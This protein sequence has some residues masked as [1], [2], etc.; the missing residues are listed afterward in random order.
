[1]R[2]NVAMRH[3]WFL[4]KRSAYF[5]EDGRKSL[6]R[7]RDSGYTVTNLSPG[8]QYLY[9]DTKIPTLEEALE[10]IVAADKYGVDRLKRICERKMISALSVENATTLLC[11]AELCNAEVLRNQAINASSLYSRM[12]TCNLIERRKQ[13][14][15]SMKSRSF[16]TQSYTR[17]KHFL[18]VIGGKGFVGSN[19]LQHALQKGIEV[20]SLNPSGKP[21]WPDAP[22]INDVEWIQG[23][24]F[25]PT[26]VSLA[27]KGI[28]GVISTVG[29]F[30]NQDHMEKLCGDATISAVTEAKK[31]G[32][33][34]F[35]FI[36]NSKVG[37]FIPSWSPLYGYYHGKERAEASI[38]EN[39]PETGVC[40][41]PGFIY[42]WRRTG[43]TNLPL[44]LFGVPMTIASRKL[45]ALSAVVSNVPFIGS[46]M[47]AAVPV[48]ATAETS[49]IMLQNPSTLPPLG[50][51]LQRLN[52]AHVLH[53]NTT[54]KIQYKLEVKRPAK[55][56]SKP[57]APRGTTLDNQP[58]RKSQSHYTASPSSATKLM[59]FD[60]CWSPAASL[61]PRN[62]YL[63]E[64]NSILPVHSYPEAQHQSTYCVQQKQWRTLIFP[65]LQPRTRQQVI[66]LQ[67]TLQKMIQNHEESSSD[68][69]SL[70]CERIL[71]EYKV[72]QLCFHELIRQM[73]FHCREQG[74]L[75]FHIYRRY[76]EMLK[77]L[78]DSLAQQETMTQRLEQRLKDLQAQQQLTP[79]QLIPSAVEDEDEPKDL[80][81]MIEVVET[82]SCECHAK[83][84]QVE[85]MAWQIQRLEL[86][87]Q[88]HILTRSLRQDAKDDASLD[89]AEISCERL[90]VSWEKMMHAAVFIQ[91]RFRAFRVY[92]YVKHHR[93]VARVRKQCRC[94][95]V[96]VTCIQAAVRRFFARQK[97]LDTRAL[98]PADDSHHA[99]NV[100]NTSPL[101]HIENLI[102]ALPELKRFIEEE[103]SQAVIVSRN[104]KVRDLTL[105]QAR[106]LSVRL[107]DVLGILSIPEDTSSIQETSSF[108]MEQPLPRTYRHAS[109]STSDFACIV[110]HEMIQNDKH[111]VLDDGGDPGPHLRVIQTV[112]PILIAE[113]FMEP[114]EPSYY[115]IPQVPTL[116][117]SNHPETLLVPLPRKQKTKLIT[118]RQFMTTIYDILLDKMKA[119]LQPQQIY[120]CEWRPISD[121]LLATKT[122]LCYSI[123]EWQ[124]GWDNRGLLAKLD[125]VH[126]IQQHFRFQF[127]L[128]NLTESAWKHLFDSL[129]Q[130]ASMHPD[131]QRFQQLLKMR[132]ESA[133]VIFYLICRQLAWNQSKVS[134]TNRSLLVHPESVCEVVTMEQARSMAWH[135][136]R[137][138]DEGQITA[139]D[140]ALLDVN[141]QLYRRYLP[142]SGYLQ[143]DQLMQ[144]H[145]P[146]ASLTKEM[147]F[148]NKALY[149]SRSKQKSAHPFSL[150][151]PKSPKLPTIDDVADKYVYFDNVVDLLCK[152]K[153]EAHH[154]HSCL[155]RIL[156]LFGDDVGLAKDQF[157]ERLKDFTT[158]TTE[159]EIGNIYH[160]MMRAN[161][162][163][164]EEL[165]TRPVFPSV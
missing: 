65:A 48:E 161:S 38:R 60:A 152:Y 74:D 34:R 78:I 117:S 163:A 54:D 41:R 36:S 95:V 149:Q 23:S 88:M 75:L 139:A 136:F 106:E 31:A 119:L 99:P 69:S 39:F 12:S 138:D 128:E 71:A 85:E 51:A 3:H 125:I 8:L 113:A 6:P 145:I 104:S 122:A 28:T 109:T 66:H 37:S 156:E 80:T 25:D 40:L 160:C 151:S 131:V 15:M 43:S 64:T 45:G 115:S 91:R 148:E 165:M 18:L 86:E 120:K 46:E 127:G 14:K 100:E 123:S 13:G 97:K 142:K 70:R 61:I 162:Q 21:S 116:H 42:G 53:N 111:E 164:E 126:A 108:K 137:V 10:L 2:R 58:H 82:C 135:L 93:A 103:S 17:S 101:Q 110:P 130:F 35:V 63:F 47:S 44:Q 73:H 84:A 150:H 118:L 94:Q 129:E 155:S 140:E 144:S 4:T 26:D 30:G 52:G 107:H 19:T 157:V 76:D 134:E 62:F 98:L 77:H 154:F 132:S 59:Q 102:V 87:V 29:T 89:Q 7:D 114:W 33:Q 121:E 49:Q 112:S 55:Q 158:A 90:R 1:M 16:A 22:W 92:K 32:I 105:T 81:P 24:V 67:E 20:R 9:C 147:V 79:T 143:F 56:P 146:K 11:I 72:Y 68:P 159:R 124:D 133:D 27:M 57:Q 153:A 141:H 50:E 83:S 96:A 5:S